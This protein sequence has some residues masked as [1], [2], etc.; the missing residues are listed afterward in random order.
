MVLLK[1]LSEPLCALRG[2]V[3]QHHR[4]RGVWSGFTK[5]RAVVREV[6][7]NLISGVPGA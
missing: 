5:L 2:E 4:A 3:E 1:G 6:P 7:L